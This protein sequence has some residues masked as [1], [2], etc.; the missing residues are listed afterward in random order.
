MT[1]T[2]AMMARDLDEMRSDLP[3]TM[4]CGADEDVEATFGAVT[5]RD[6]V[7]E[8]GILNE[9]EL[10]GV[11]RRD[12]WTDSTPPAIRKTVTVTCSGLGLSAVKYHIEERTVDPGGVT[13]QLK[14]I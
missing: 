1:L 8:E 7:A 9:Q 14:R 11:T 4:S 5:R 2:A 6:E 12:G 13:F 10:E 3:G